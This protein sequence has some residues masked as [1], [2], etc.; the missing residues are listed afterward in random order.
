M[1]KYRIDLQSTKAIEIETDSELKI[2]DIGSMLYEIQVGGKT[3]VT[4]SKSEF[5][6]CLEV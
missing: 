2:V 3:K 6:S 1:K 4:I 5:I